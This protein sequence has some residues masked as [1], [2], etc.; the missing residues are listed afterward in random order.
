M[1]F[2]SRSKISIPLSLLV[3]FA[4]SLA[5]LVSARP[6]V[7]AASPGITL[8]VNAGPPTTV[9]MIH[10]TGFK[11]NE[12]VTLAFETTQLA[13]I[14]S[15]RSG[16]FSVTLPVP[17]SAQPGTHLIHALGQTSG[18]V[19]QATFLV[20]TNWA[21]FGFNQRNT[22]FNPYE[23]VLTP[24]NVSGLTLDWIYPGGFYNSSSPAVANGV[25]Y[26][27]SGDGNLYALDAATGALKWN[28]S[29]GPFRSSPAVAN[30]LV[31]IGS[32][33]NK[34]Y[35]LD[36]TTG[37]LKWSY[38]TGGEIG[39]SPVVANG[40]VYVGSDDGK[41]YALDATTGTL[42]WSYATGGSIESSSPAVANGLVYIGSDD[43]KLYALGATTGK[44]KWSSASGYVTL[45]VA[46]GVV[47]IDSGACKLYALDAATGTLKWSS[48][49]GCGPLAV[50][51]GVVYANDDGNLYA[52][53]AV[54][55][56]LKWNHP[57]GTWESASAPVIAN[58]VIYI[59]GS[60]PDDKLYALDA[61]KG[62][63]LWSNSATPGNYVY[64]DSSLAVVNGVVY[65]SSNNNILYAFHLPGMTP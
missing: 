41:L 17:K 23:N 62:T 19:A 44:L 46:N 64:I 28:Y 65:G 45:A 5:M 6:I 11:G 39:S 48:A 3:V 29:Y 49:S 38:A 56:A 59:S 58:G 42:K 9:T 53:D 34:L 12:L 61:R 10:G 25:A 24:S 35:A 33:D 26:V 7:R 13:S 18:N 36:A 52:F 20:Q 54:T 51:N 22:R 8:S 63:L 1:R 43:G 30:G 31:Y 16:T 47:Y 40:L 4:A 50:A 2:S 55:G 15:S 32:N 27:G 37:T 57:T 60:Y 14:T 21:E